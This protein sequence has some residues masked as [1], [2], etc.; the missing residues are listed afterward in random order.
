LFDLTTLAEIKA[1]LLERGK[2]ADALKVAIFATQEFPH[3]SDSWYH[4]GE[5]YLHIGDKKQALESIRRSLA[6]APAHPE[7]IRLLQQVESI[8]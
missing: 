5:T 3:H 6:L 7:T 8:G 4:L 2:P 1:K